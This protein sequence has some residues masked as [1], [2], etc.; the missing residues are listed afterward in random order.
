L[1]QVVSVG[2][3]NLTVTEFDGEGV[4]VITGQTLLVKLPEGLWTQVPEGRVA[5]TQDRQFASVQTPPV[6]VPLGL[7]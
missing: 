4:M 3:N 1:A 5:P 7:H 6:N 2:E